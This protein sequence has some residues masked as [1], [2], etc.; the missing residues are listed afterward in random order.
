M[1]G[2]IHFVSDY[3][4]EHAAIEEVG[5]DKLPEQL[6]FFGPY[7]TQRHAKCHKWLWAGTAL[8]LAGAIWATAH[9]TAE[10]VQSNAVSI[11]DTGASAHEV[12][13][14]I[15]DSISLGTNVITEAI[16]VGVV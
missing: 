12:G 10:N 6:G 3:V 2:P 9:T 4:R 7:E 11:G 14:S 1:T 8:G 13:T 5:E 16:I 15:A